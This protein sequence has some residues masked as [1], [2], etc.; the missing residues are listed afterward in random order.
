MAGVTYAAAITYLW[1][2]QEKLLFAPEV[3]PRGHAFKLDRDVHELAIDVPGATLNALHLRLPNPRGVV[4]Y[5]H[6]NTGNLERWFVDLDLF[7]RAHVDLFMLDY[8]G[9]GKSSGRIESEAQLRADVRAAWQHIASRYEGKRRVILGRSLG[10][11]LA[12]QLS[13]EVRPELTVLVSPYTSMESLVGEMYPWVPS[14]ALRY[15][16]RTDEA[17]KRLRNP[18]LIVHGGRDTFIAP[19]HGRTLASLALDARFV[20]VP[21]AGHRNIVDTAGYRDAL[22]RHL[23]P[24]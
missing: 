11:A 24:R 20:L 1:Q 3:L 7:R 4:F 6:G 10:S 22:R 13:A 16:L 5:L 9:Y 17:V 14:A 2:G 21:E 12:A 23:E 15:P 8:R 18:L 19:E